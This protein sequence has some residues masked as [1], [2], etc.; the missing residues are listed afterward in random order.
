MASRILI[1]AAGVCLLLASWLTRKRAEKKRPGEHA[2]LSPSV[3]AALIVRQS[4]T[5]RRQLVIENNGSAMALRIYF[6]VQ[7]RLT[8]KVVAPGSREL[9]LIDAI[10]PGVGIEC[11]RCRVRQGTY[12]VALCWLNEDGA[13][14]IK[15]RHIVTVR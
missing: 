13:S 7:H 10:P 4:E 15:T 8:G 5:G 2:C 14:N 12:V 3:E 9:G 11:P 1:I 6:Q